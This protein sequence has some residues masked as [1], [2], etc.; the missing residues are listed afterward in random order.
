MTVKDRYSGADMRSRTIGFGD[1]APSTT[2]AKIFWFFYEPLGI[3]NLAVA[4]SITRDTLLE[5][6]EA[7]YRRRS[8]RLR[9][10]LKERKR[11]KAEDRARHQAIERQ[12]LAIGAPLYVGSKGSAGGRHHAPT[13]KL[14]VSALSP[15]QLEQAELEARNEISLGSASAGQSHNDP[16]VDLDTR[17]NLAL[18]EA[19]RL[20]D[21]LASQSVS[22]EEG[23]KQFIDTISAEEKREKAAKVS[24]LVACSSSVSRP[25]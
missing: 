8:E 5:S 2:S 18:Q 13:A 21:E 25:C 12:L 10:R 23:Y 17:R 19:R 14:N 6:W 20:Q 11:Q 9:R 16:S 24:S 4:V 22:S 3:L 7:A 1:I 15:E